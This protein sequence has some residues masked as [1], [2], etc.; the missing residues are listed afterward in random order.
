MPELGPADPHVDLGDA[1]LVSDRQ[2]RLFE[3]TA[4]LLERAGDRT[5]VVFAV[6]DLHWCDRA[7]L[8][9]LAYL[10]RRLEGLPVLVLASLRS[11]P[12]IFIVK[13]WSQA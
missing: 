12:S 13:I 8:R 7:S 9:F 6:D 3:P 4:G 10:V 11:E 5:A 1:A 2:L